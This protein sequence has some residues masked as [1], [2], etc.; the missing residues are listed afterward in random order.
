MLQNYMIII[1]LLLYFFEETFIFLFMCVVFCSHLF[2]CTMCMEC[3]QKSEE[4]M[5]SHGAGI[6]DSSRPVVYRY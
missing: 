1:I 6:T 3:S 4:A 2:S 5:R